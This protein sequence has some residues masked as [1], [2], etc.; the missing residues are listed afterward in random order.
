MVPLDTEPAAGQAPAAGLDR[1]SQLG[2]RYTTGDTDDPFELLVT[3]AGDGTLTADG[4]P[5]VFKEAK[6]LPASD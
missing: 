3:K 2:K 4:A 1:G 6:P 5:L